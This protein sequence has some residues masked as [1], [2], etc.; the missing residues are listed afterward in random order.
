MFYQDEGGGSSNM[1]TEAPSN[2]PLAA[3]NRNSL[4]YEEVVRE[5]IACEKAYIKELHMLIKV[6]RYVL[7]QLVRCCELQWVWNFREEIIKLNSDSVEVDLIFSNI[8]D[9]Y[10][11]TY[12]L[13]GSLED[14]IEMAQDQMPYIGSCFEGTFERSV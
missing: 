13:S 9:I 12:T 6:F 1:L 11:L 10:E 3:P 8:I 5:L 14:V 2:E 4:T 7:E